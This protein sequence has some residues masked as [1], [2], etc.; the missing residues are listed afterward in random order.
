M[1]KVEKL[2]VDLEDL[3]DL[4]PDEEETIS[5]GIEKKVAEIAEKNGWNLD[6]IDYRSSVK[7]ELVVSSDKIK[8]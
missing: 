3:I 4:T 7:V 2:T 1:K 5:C 6:T 8:R